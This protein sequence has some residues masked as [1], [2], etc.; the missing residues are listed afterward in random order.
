MIGVFDSG[1]GGLTVLR[2]LH[3]AMPTHDF[4]YLGDHH[5]AP[6]GDRTPEEIYQL[7]LDSVSRLFDQGARLVVLA[8][9]TASAVA[10]RRLQQTWL[11]GAY[12]GRRVLGVLVPMV[13]AIT[14]VP[15]MAD[16]AADR[17]AG[18]P[19]TI[20][21]F[22]TSRTVDSG[23]YPREVSHRA[24]EVRVVQQACP[25]LV[26]LIEGDAPPAQVRDAIHRYTDGLL[27][28]LGGG[29]P[30]AVMLGCTHYPLVAD[31]FI[32]A[33]PQ[34][35]EVL[36][37]PDLTA[38]SLAAYLQRHPEFDRPGSGQVQFLTTGEAGRITLLATRFFGKPARFERV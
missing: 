29:A 12:P 38:R 13:E 28:Q 5:F 27:G 31:A 16:L 30:Q 6:Y 20:G 34:G 24:P 9:N 25:E 1:H 3:D 2:A 4:L 10:L 19:R 11:D 32:T 36:S 37:Q 14:G 22:A 21:I 17:P 33:L 26:R 18:P 35:V 8:C 23:A 15:W 7:T